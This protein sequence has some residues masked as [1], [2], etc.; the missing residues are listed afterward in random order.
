MCQRND[1]ATLWL[2]CV[3]IPFVLCSSGASMKMNSLCILQCGHTMIRADPFATSGWCLPPE[4]PR[5]LGKLDDSD[6]TS[7]NSYQPRSRVRCE[8]VKR[9]FALRIHH[10]KLCGG[11]ISPNG[12][13]VRAT[14]ATRPA[15]ETG[16]GSVCG[17]S[18]ADTSNIWGRARS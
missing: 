18:L 7:H 3:C 15:D 17:K 5:R 12:L 16:R 8:S 9:E 2:L 13:F 1:L 6:R 4:I 14:Q 10:T 11:R